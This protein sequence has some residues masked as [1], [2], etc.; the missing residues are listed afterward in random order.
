[1]LIWASIVIIVAG[2]RAAASLVVPLLLA[3]FLAILCGP[4]LEWLIRRGLRR[5]LAM[6]IV[7]GALCVV[8][9]IVARVLATTAG[10]FIEQWPTN[11]QLRA[12]AIAADWQE[13]FEDRTESWIRTLSPERPAAAPD[14]ED[15]R[16]PEE[17]EPG[18]N[19]LEEPTRDADEPPPARSDAPPAEPQPPPV[20][21]PAPTDGAALPP[22]GFEPPVDGGLTAVGPARSHWDDWLEPNFLMRSFTTGMRAVSG[23]LSQALLILV[24]TIFLLVEATSLPEKLQAI[25][26]DAPAR[27]EKLQHIAHEVNQYMAIKTATSL[28]TGS[29]VALALWL[30]DIDFALL[31]GMTAFLLNFVPQIGS[32]IA[33]VPAILLALLQHGFPTAVVVAGI[34]L[35][36]NMIVSYYLEPKWMGRGLGL[37]T[38]VVFGSLVFWGWVLGPVGMVISVPLT[39]TVKIALEGSPE[40]RWLAILMGSGGESSIA[41]A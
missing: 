33:A 24:M 9:L 23:I 13:W 12:E 39:M 17:L 25:S 14:E 7:I 27:L 5:G 22:P 2:L 15:L 4:P 31:W 3:L 19:L 34:Y 40:T 28:L 10:N 1:M 36:I 16:R 38:L 29:G 20:E 11:Y 18:L 37:S 30:L 21:A 41:K 8:V 26:S 32:I 35:G 6:L